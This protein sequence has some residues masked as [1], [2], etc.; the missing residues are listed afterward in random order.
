MQLATLSNFYSKKKKKINIL[1][2]IQCILSREFLLR[3][4]L[5]VCVCCLY[6]LNSVSIPL[7]NGYHLSGGVG[8]EGEED[9]AFV[10]TRY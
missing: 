9:E 8:G 2:N 5:R 10:F 6:M 4:T 3:A 1:L 7:G